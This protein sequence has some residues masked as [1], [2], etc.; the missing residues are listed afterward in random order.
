MITRYLFIFFTF[1]WLT[2]QPSYA[3]DLTS[4]KGELHLN[5]P[6]SRIVSYDLAVLDT[7]HTLGITAV[8]VPQSMYKGHWESYQNA[9]V[10]GTLFE[11]DYE[12][13]K[14]LQPELIFA[15][16]RSERAVPLLSK[17]APVAGYTTDTS[18]FVASFTKNNLDLARA[19]HKESDAQ[20]ILDSIHHNVST[21]Q[22]R[23]QDKT[24]IFLFIINNNIIAHAPG[25]RF[26]YAYELTGLTS[27]ITAAE[28]PQTSSTRPEPGS[29]EAH[30]L[31][32]AR[33][34]TIQLI[35]ERNP[36]WLIVLDRGAI[37]DAEKTAAQT[38]AN[39]PQLSKLDAVQQGRVYYADPNPWYVISGGLTNM[40]TI[41]NHLVEHLK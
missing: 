25:D 27:V 28:M 3:F 26:G 5:T 35:V 41:T 6:P 4:N 29:A 39:H 1:F 12:A 9:P 36:D 16:G 18:N 32:K 20:H 2:V 23:N 7:L 10:V 17:I 8:G 14:A 22:E 30:A 34:E 40:L 37:N 38:I 11:P 31:Q 21:L 33:A 15:G 24:G 13:L 19:F